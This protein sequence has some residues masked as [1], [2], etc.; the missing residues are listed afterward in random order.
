MARQQNITKLFNCKP[1][2]PQKVQLRTDDDLEGA[3]FHP[4]PAEQMLRMANERFTQAAGVPSLEKCS[5]M[6]Y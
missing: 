4:M 1:S 6:L 5:Y 2:E 3:G